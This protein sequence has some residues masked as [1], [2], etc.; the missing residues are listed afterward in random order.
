MSERK[1][2]KYTYY[3]LGCHKEFR[4]DE[5]YE[6]G[7]ICRKCV[8]KG[9]KLTVKCCDCG[10]D[11]KISWYTY[12]MKEDKTIWRCDEC[13]AKYQSKLGKEY[14]NNKTDEEKKLHSEKSKE[15]WKDLTPEQKREKQKYMT[16]GHAQ[17]F[18]NEEKVKEFGNK[19]S[20]SLLKYFENESEEE[21]EKR[22]NTQ[23]EIAN[24]KTYKEKI[25]HLKPAHTVRNEYYKNR[26]EEE[27]LA[28]NK[29]ISKG[30]LRHFENES[31][32]SKQRRSDIMIERYVNMSEEEKKE[33]S[34]SIIKGLANRPE[35]DKIN[36][37]EKISKSLINFHKD[38][39]P[40]ERKLMT[41]AARDAYRN[42]LDN[43]S[44]DEKNKWLKPMLDAN[45]L[46]REN[47]TYDDFIL[48]MEKLST[49]I[50]NRSNEEKNKDIDSP[51]ELQFIEILNKEKLPYN[52][53]YY[54]TTI[55]P[56]FKELFPWNHYKK[57]ENI[58]P[59]HE[60]DFMI[61]T[62]LHDIFVDVDGSIHKPTRS[63]SK[64]VIDFNNSILFNDS[65]RPYQRDNNQAYVIL[66]YNDKIDDYTTVIR[67]DKEEKILF[68]TFIE[69]LHLY[70]GDRPGK[71]NVIDIL[72]KEKE[73]DK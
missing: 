50:N 36:Q 25:E 72:I 7:F 54:N 23:K 3:C 1:H 10:K 47:L 6:Y 60:W 64:A 42:W 59:Y 67:L 21:K 19:V 24:Q 66:A 48:I 34:E 13:N 30:Q 2:F 70:N 15:Q 26:T 40:E 41:K 62:K 51:S 12:K 61:K 63:T 73:N 31:E 43:L 22:I 32:E 52:I 39:T 68:K 20:S 44:D 33:F 16:E 65:Q 58:S 71:N 35:E 4:T 27:R 57:T 49:T 53:H 45:E 69:T 55:N 14:W 37:Y 8:K 11:I 46:W 38:D 18:S 56:R 17:Y 9:I 29:K 5:F 28:D